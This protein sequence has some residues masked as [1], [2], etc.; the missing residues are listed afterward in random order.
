MTKGEVLAVTGSSGSGKSTIASLILKLYEPDTGAIYFS[1][2]ASTD[3]SK[4][5]VRA[6]IGVVE[7]DSVLFSGTIKEN[8]LYGRLAATQAEVEAAARTAHAHDFI[9]S[10][11]D[12]YDTCVGER[13][14][15]ALSGGERQRVAI[16]R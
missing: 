6:K 10:L 14:T 12:K 13:G 9:M 3:M 15:V 16:A 8:I 11:P 2:V 4:Q 5:E 7:Q 1:G